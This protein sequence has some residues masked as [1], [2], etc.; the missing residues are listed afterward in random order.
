MPAGRYG[1]WGF[2]QLDSPYGTADAVRTHLVDQA[3]AA[4]AF[5][6]HRGLTWDH[7]V[8]PMFVAYPPTLRRNFGTA[9]R[10]LPLRPTGAER[11]GERWGSRDDGLAIA[12]GSGA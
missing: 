6:A 9:A 4:G 8:M 1:R 5:R 3:P 7:C 11:V 12:N 10:Q 2:L